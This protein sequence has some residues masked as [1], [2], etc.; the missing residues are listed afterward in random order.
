MLSEVPGGECFSG[1]CYPLTGLIGDSLVT[2]SVGTINTVNQ[3]LTDSAG[4]VWTLTPNV[5]CQTNPPDW[6][7]AG[8]NEN[9]IQQICG[10]IMDM[11]LLN[12]G[13]VWIEFAKEGGWWDATL[14]GGACPTCTNLIP[15]LQG[16][17]GPG[18][19]NVSSGGGGGAGLPPVSW[20]GGGPTD[21]LAA[22]EDVGATVAAVNT[23]VIEFC[24]GP[25]NN[26]STTGNLLNGA[27]K[28]TAGGNGLSD[29]SNAVAHPVV[30]TGLAGKIAYSIDIYPSNLGGVSPD[31]PA[32]TITPIWN[33]YFG[34]A[35]SSLPV[36]DMETG[37][38]CDGTTGSLT[39]DNAMMTAWTAWANG[40][41]SGGPTFTT[42]QQPISNVWLAWGN[43]PGVNPDGT[44][45]TNGTL[46]V[47]QQTW[48]S[49]LLFGTVAPPPPPP[50]TAWNPSDQAGMT[51]SV[52]NTVATSAI[53]GGEGVR[54]SASR[55]TGAN[56][57]WAEQASGTI[58]TDWAA[59][60]ANS[61]ANLS[62]SGGL[63]GDTTAIV[64][65]PNSL[66][67]NQSIYFNNVA[68]NVAGATA[69]ANGDTIMMCA[70]LTTDLFYATDAAMV[71]HFG[72]G[73]WNSSA[74]C[75]PTVA[76][77]GVSFSGMT[78]PF[79]ILY[80]NDQSGSAST[81]L[82]TSAQM[83]YAIPSGY[84]AW[85]TAAV[86]GSGRPMGVV[87]MGDNDHRPASDDGAIRIA[88]NNR[89]MRR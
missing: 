19:N 7:W 76:A 21:V 25:L 75:N 59:G 58:T 61:S 23:G 83:P 31:S 29:L 69:S 32:A 67:G 17:P 41:V 42:S 26:G 56:V 85:D 28:P 47:G 66:G 60:L 18:P 44:Q 81:I 82:T 65:D 73:S 12:N 50:T 15:F 35:M 39:D 89:S 64:I 3:S 72:A 62:T 48:W 52:N 49:T 43:Y 13:H 78:G 1:T 2:T 5:P 54:S 86:A 22:C 87:I 27:T 4:N 20:G 6:W 46:K 74:S 9:G 77:C 38:S 33:S 30:G 34:S 14:Y 88:L 84:V 79:F 71:A 57:C 36:M 70:N 40:Q 55:A 24:P 63:G 10:Y 37:C 51:L 68:S 16:D 45:N 8:L 53:T 80:N 11:R